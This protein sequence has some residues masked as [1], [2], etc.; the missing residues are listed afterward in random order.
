[1]QSV[2]IIIFEFIMMDN[3]RLESMVSTLTSE[4]GKL[5][6]FKELFEQLKE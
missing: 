3:E 5:A 6:E 4:V 1:M 2:L